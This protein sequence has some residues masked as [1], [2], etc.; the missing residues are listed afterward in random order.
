MNCQLCQKK[1][2]A[3]RDGKL[4]RDMMI[5]VE[6]H[7]KECRTCAE[8]IK[9][10]ILADRVIDKEKELSSDPFL[11]TRVMACIDTLE[12]SGYKPSSL[13]IRTLK[14]VLITASMAAAIFM[15]IMI[16]NISDS[17][18]PG[19]TLPVELALIDDATIESVSILSNE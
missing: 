15:G 5:Q 10:L 1:L 19:D 16:G 8:I 9:Q 14:P 13:F 12:N 6:S 2:D 4:P 11:A 7:L 17:V 3:Y 18:V